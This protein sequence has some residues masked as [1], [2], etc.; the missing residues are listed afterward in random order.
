M[1]AASTDPS[2]PLSEAIEAALTLPN[3]ARFHRC[4]LQI[5]PYAYLFSKQ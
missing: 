1:T 5:N 3:G 2:A 4:A